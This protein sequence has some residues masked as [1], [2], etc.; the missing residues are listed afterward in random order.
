MITY[1][2]IWE[3]NTSRREV[4]DSSHVSE[5]SHYFVKRRLLQSGLLLSKILN[6]A[7]KYTIISNLSRRELWTEIF[8]TGHFT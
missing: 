7:I 6:V 3:L 2:G 4:A 8:Y 1:I 5:Y